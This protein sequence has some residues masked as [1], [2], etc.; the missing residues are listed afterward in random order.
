[1]NSLFDIFNDNNKVQNVNAILRGMGYVLDSNF[2]KEHADKS[3][4]ISDLESLIKNNKIDKITRDQVLDAFLEFDQKST[5]KIPIGKMKSILSGGENPLTEEEIDAAI[6]IL[7]PNP[8]GII[9]YLKHGLID[10]CIF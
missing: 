2:I 5:G 8:E 10:Q 9:E 7:N 3:M 1:M 4:S 6:E